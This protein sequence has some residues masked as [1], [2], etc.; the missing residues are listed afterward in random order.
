MKIR[1]DPLLTLSLSE[2]LLGQVVTEAIISRRVG[3]LGVE[4]C[5][6]YEYEHVQKG[7]IWRKPEQIMRASGLWD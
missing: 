3:T 2:V 7:L 5:S 6:M 4:V 1:L